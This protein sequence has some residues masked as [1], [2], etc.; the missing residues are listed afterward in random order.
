MHAR[1]ATGVRPPPLAFPTL[2]PQIHKSRSSQRSIREALFHAANL[3]PEVIEL[4]VLN[5]RR[6]RRTKK[7]LLQRLRAWAA[8]V[9]EMKQQ[10]LGEHHALG[11]VAPRPYKAEGA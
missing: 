10:S 3:P 8:E 7:P 11:R 5:P 9:V 6:L 1:V 4:Y 2:A